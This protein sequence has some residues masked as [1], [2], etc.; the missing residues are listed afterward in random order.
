MGSILLKKRTIVTCLLLILITDSLFLAST[1]FVKNYER[2]WYVLNFILNC[3]IIKGSQTALW[4]GLLEIFSSIVLVAIKC[5]TL[6]AGG[7]YLAA[8]THVVCGHIVFYVLDLYHHVDFRIGWMNRMAH[9]NGAFGRTVEGRVKI[10]HQVK[11]IIDVS[12]AIVWRIWHWYTRGGR[13]PSTDDCIARDLVSIYCIIILKEAIWSAL[14]VE[15]W[16]LWFAT[17][18]LQTAVIYFV[19]Q[20]IWTPGLV[21][22]G[23][24]GYLVAAYYYYD[25]RTLYS[26]YLLF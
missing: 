3:A 18:A 19:M 20:L 9:K 7:L 16:W 6:E 22:L 14:I 8:F 11:I 17:V 10:I 4:L 1:P 26:R 15:D 23:F 21:L 12:L 24:V 5:K 25:F 13:G 2:I